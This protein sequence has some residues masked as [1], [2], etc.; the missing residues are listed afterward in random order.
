MTVTDAGITRPERQRDDRVAT[1]AKLKIVYIAGYG[2]S[3]TTLLSI[4]LGEHPA[5]CSAGELHELTRSAWSQN[6]FCSCGARMRDCSF[7]GSVMRR[8]LGSAPDAV[9]DAYQRVQSPIE[10]SFMPS[11]LK[12]GPQSKVFAERTHA[13]FDE[14]AA[15]SGNTVIVDSSKLPGRAGALARDRDL[16]LYVIHLV[17]DG[18][19]VAWSLRKAYQ[20][21][22]KA[23]VQRELKPKPTVRTSLRWS[24]VNLAAE[25]L[26]GAVGKDRYLRV[27]YED[28]AADPAAVLG[29][30]GAMI[31]VDLGA[32]G[33]NLKDGAGMNPRHQLAGSRLRMNSSIKVAIDEGWRSQM[34]T[35]SRR[36][37]TL[38]S[39]PHLQRYGYLEPKGRRAAP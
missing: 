6:N 18:R 26:A 19:G 22:A 13:L 29:R 27:R 11:F 14:I 25:R 8:W 20:R 23:G 9:L 33:A 4:A 34:P 28:F 3:G 39:W 21:D 31:G 17:R 38:L 36:L 12:T 1:R 2:R 37:F 5:I 30:I 7:W 32:V 15:A 35:M 24:L 16:D 10:N